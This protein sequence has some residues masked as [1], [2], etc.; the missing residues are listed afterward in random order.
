MRGDWHNL[1]V[2]WFGGAWQA[3]CDCGFRFSSADPAQTARA[4]QEHERTTV[5]ALT[6]MSDEALAVREAERIIAHARDPE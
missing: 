3:R 2:E 5:M 6:P 1:D 4:A